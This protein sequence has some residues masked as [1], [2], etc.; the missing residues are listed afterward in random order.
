MPEKSR[1]NDVNPNRSSSPSE[2]NIARESEKFDASI[3]EELDALEVNLTQDADE[4]RDS[5]D[6]TGLIDDELAEE[7]V[8]DLTEVGPDLDNKGVVNAAPGRDDTSSTLRR[9]Y[10]NA[11]SG[12]AEDVTDDNLDEPRDEVLTDRNFDEDTAA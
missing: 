5:D 8:E 12:Q 1:N 4:F 11:P 7:R 3:D 2:T 10:A 9:H 6:G